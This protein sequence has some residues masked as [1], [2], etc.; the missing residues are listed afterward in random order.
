MCMYTYRHKTDAVLH[1]LQ[2][3]HNS[4]FSSIEEECSTIPKMSWSC[5]LEVNELLIYC[6]CQATTFS[7]REVN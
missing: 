6:S 5:N 1:I 3:I 2:K 7:W 4:I